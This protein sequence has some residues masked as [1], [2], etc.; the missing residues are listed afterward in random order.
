MRVL[1]RIKDQDG[2]FVDRSSHMMYGAG[3]DW[4]VEQQAFGNIDTFNF[5]LDDP[6]LD[7]GYPA[8]R[9][10]VLEVRKEDPADE[11]EIIFAGI[12]TEV[13]DET[14]GL[15]LR[16]RCVALGWGF[17]FDRTLVTARYVGKSDQYIITEA[18]ENPLNI[19]RSSDDPQFFENW[20]IMPGDDNVRVGVAN[21]EFYH[22]QDQTLRN[23]L[24]TLATASGYVWR[25]EPRESGGDVV[26]AILYHPLEGP[27]NNVN[28]SDGSRGGV[29]TND[30]DE[31]NTAGDSPTLPCHA[32]RRRIDTSKL[33]NVVKVEGGHRELFTQART[34]PG[35]GESTTYTGHDRFHASEGQ[36][37]IQ[38]DVNTGTNSS[39]VWTSLVVGLDGF[40]QIGDMDVNGNVINVIWSPV[41]FTLRF[42]T[43]PPN[44]PDNAYR[45]SGDMLQRIIDSARDNSSISEFGQKSIIIRDNTLITEA[46]VLARARGELR[47]R[48]AEVDRVVCSVVDIEIEPGMSSPRRQLPRIGVAKTI[49]ITNS[50]RRLYKKK[51][52]VDKVT[53]RGM[54]SD[55][56]R[57]ELTLRGIAQIGD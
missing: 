26:G 19:F 24:D 1:L 31:I 52:F 12:I 2:M 6:N 34:Y 37:R 20:I 21:T 40:D 28:L 39:P 42:Q 22:F 14:V 33:V 51:Y 50:A 15:G 9:E 3:Y 44:F 56:S 43:P 38:V 53:I 10:I 16:Y 57:Y 55:V 32:M 49:R 17:K 11:T 5:V 36:Q 41:L 18:N 48:I 8:N 30:P 54:G 46:E 35:D 7:L 27:E 25:I 47:K 13:G 29:P 4:V 23:I 45:I